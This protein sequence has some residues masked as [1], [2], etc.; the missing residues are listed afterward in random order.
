MRFEWDENKNNANH[1]K[2]GVWFDEAQ[3]IWADE[4]SREFFDPEH[5]DEEDRFVR[6]GFSS[7]NRLLLIV[8]CE[9]Q[10][11]SK[12]VLIR[13]ISARKATTEEQKQYEKGI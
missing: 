8:F 9:R 11:E 10:E 7:K 5:S 3:T 1:Q 12:E 4:A 6:I 13:I 2:H